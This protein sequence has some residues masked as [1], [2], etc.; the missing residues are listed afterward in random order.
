MLSPPVGLVTRHGLH[1]EHAVAPG[2]LPKAAVLHQPSTHQWKLS[3]FCASS[4]SSLG[5]RMV[6][7]LI[8][9]LV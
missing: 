5:L 2:V 8:V 9:P 7:F 1:A 6:G 4:S 3:V